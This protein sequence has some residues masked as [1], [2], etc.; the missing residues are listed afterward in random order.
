M[1]LLFLRRAG[2]MLTPNL[3]VPWL[4]DAPS[5]KVKYKTQHR[6]GMEVKTKPGPTSGLL[7]SGAPENS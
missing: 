6:G 7:A 5:E 1:L 4:P 2:P 3:N